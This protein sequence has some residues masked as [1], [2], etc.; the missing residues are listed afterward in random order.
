MSRPKSIG[1]GAH[2]TN[3]SI[4]MLDNGTGAP[5]TGHSVLPGNGMYTDY[6]QTLAPELLILG[7]NY[8]ISV[9]H[10]FSNRWPREVY[11]HV[12]IDFNRNGSFE[13]SERVLSVSDIP[14]EEEYATTFGNV[15]VPSNAELGLTR[16]R[17]M[18]STAPFDTTGSDSNSPCGFYD[19]QGETEDYAIMLSNPLPVDLGVAAILHPVGEV[20]ADSNA[21]MRV[22]LRNY[23]TLPQT[24]SVSH[25]ANVTVNITGAVPGTYTQ[26][27]ESGTLEPDGELVVSFPNVNVSALGQYH[28]RAHLTYEGDQYQVNDTRSID[29]KVSTH[30]KELPFEESFRA[31][32]AD[33]VN[34]KL[35]AGW[36]YS[37]KEDNYHWREEVGRSQNANSGPAHDHTLAGAPNQDLG[38]YVSVPGQNNSQN[39]GIYNKFT[40]LTSRC[41]NMHYNNGYPSELSFYKY[42]VNKS[43]ADFEMYVEVGSGDYY[44]PIALLTKADGTQT[45]SNDEWSEHVIMLDSVDEVARLRFTVTHQYKK[46][47]RALMTSTLFLADPIWQ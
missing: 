33:L 17:V 16:M 10:A 46:L 26:T 37:P 14:D 31:A 30:P 27:V 35:P 22:K 45:G 5:F 41:I 44:R 25:P 4:A 19:A 1:S 15:E 2:I 18:C 39:Q 36:D 24:L 9:T 13:T 43:D 47:I 12:Y 28:V 11:K 6:T 20:C 7:Q 3:V 34:P 32:N 42:F 21:T 8:P 23:G 29:A 40:S 38:G